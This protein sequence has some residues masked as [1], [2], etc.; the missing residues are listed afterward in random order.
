MTITIQVKNKGLFLERGVQVPGS[1]WRQAPFKFDPKPFAVGNE[2]LKHRILQPSVQRGS[3]EGFLEDPSI[4]GLYAVG[5]EPTADRANLF[6]AFLMHHYLSVRVNTIARWHPL[7]DRT[8]IVRNDSPCSFLVI[9][10]I[11]SKMTQYRMEKLR[12]L[13]NKYDSIPRVLVITGCDPVT[14]C[15]SEL[16]I[17]N[18]HLFYTPSPEVNRKQP[19]VV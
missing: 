4:P 14:F 10:D 13:V 1:V 19:E 5:S 8:D 3:L 2:Y 6:A 15:Q 17:A 18:T 12:D 9:S 11:Y 16:H 7:W